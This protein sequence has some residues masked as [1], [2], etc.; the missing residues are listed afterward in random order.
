MALTKAPLFGLDAGGTLAGAIVFSKWKG[1]TYVRRHAVPHNP[2]S[3]LQV[4]MRS[5]FKFVSQAYAALAATPKANWKAVA[6]KTS[7]TPMNAQMQRSQ[8]NARVNLGAVYDPTTGATTAP[9]APATLT[10]TAAPKSINVAWTHPAATPGDY[11]AML[12]MSTVTGFTPDVSNLVYVG[13]Q[14]TLL[15]T[16]RN[17]VTGTPYYFRLRETN[18]NGDMGALVAQATATPT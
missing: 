14:A 3:G 17:L 15:T 9:T 7:T 10:P 11:T 5:M 8:R 13:A 6:D 1:R 16:I 2:K 4:G 18:K 12:Y